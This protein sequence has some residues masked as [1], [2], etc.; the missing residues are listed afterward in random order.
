MSSF[1]NAESAVSDLLGGITFAL[2]IESVPLGF[3]L[4]PVGPPV[5]APYE[6]ELGAVDEPVSVAAAGGRVFVCAPD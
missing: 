3:M 6:P 5:V 4:C 1:L 2:D